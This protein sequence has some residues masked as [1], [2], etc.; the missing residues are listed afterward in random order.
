MLGRKPGLEK[1]YYNQRQVHQRA[2]ESVLFHQFGFVAFLVAVV[3]VGGYLLFGSFGEE[4]VDDDAAVARAQLQHEAA[5]A[6][7]APTP[8]PV[9]TAGT[10]DKADAPQS[11][12]PPPERSLPAAPP[13]T[14]P[15]DALSARDQ[16]DAT[17]AS[18]A[19]A[20]AAHRAPAAPTKAGEAPPAVADKSESGQ[21]PI[22]EH[23]AA[24]KTGAKPAPQTAAGEPGPHG[25]HSAAAQPSTTADEAGPVSVVRATFAYDYDNGRPLDPVTYVDYSRTQAGRLYYY[26]EVDAP[27]GARVVHQWRYEGSVVKEQAFTVQ[28]S[29]VATVSHQDIPQYAQGVWRVYVLAPDGRTIKIGTALYQ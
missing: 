27:Q 24:P 18:N 13:Q 26:A 8:E 5:A 22:A 11:K 3:V 29:D 9:A 21:A 10:D 25:A 17:Q 6:A 23:E 16:S 2:R 14:Q 15:S 20:G 12:Q 1:E 28:G 19:T 4:P 7:A